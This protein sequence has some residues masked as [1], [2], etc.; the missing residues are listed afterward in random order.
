MRTEARIP[1][2]L[3]TKAKLLINHNGHRS[4]NDI[5]NKALEMYIDVNSR[6]IAKIEK[7]SKR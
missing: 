7:E 1:D 5:L 3:A 6:E 2:K 4:F